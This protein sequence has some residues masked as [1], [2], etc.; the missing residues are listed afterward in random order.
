M[1][2]INIFLEYGTFLCV[3]H[4][5]FQVNYWIMSFLTELLPENMLY[6]FTE[7]V[8]STIVV[9]N[10]P[11]PQ[12]ITCVS[13]Y[14][15]SNMTFWVPHRGSTGIGISILSYGYRLQLGLIADRAVISN[16][17]DAQRILDGA[18]DEIRHMAYKKYNL[19]R[20]SVAF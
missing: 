2:N 3:V 13:G 9:S 16:Q 6:A 12:T 4:L 1:V 17:C 19:K 7:S 14:R 18:V 15:I 11:G 10:L 20:N 8:H 5:Y